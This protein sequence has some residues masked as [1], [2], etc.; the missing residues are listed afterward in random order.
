MDVKI[1]KD[2][3]SIIVHIMEE[4]LNSLKTFELEKMLLDVINV[5][6]IITIEMEKVE[7]ISSAFLAFCHRIAQIVTESNFKITGVQPHVYR[8]FQI[9]GYTDFLSITS[10]E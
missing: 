3:C 10:K 9:S 6:S 1:K 8:I 4:E 2:Q 5:D 7:Y